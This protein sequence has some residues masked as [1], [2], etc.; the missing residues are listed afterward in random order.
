[1][2]NRTY[3]C[4]KMETDVDPRLSSSVAYSDFHGGEGDY[5][6]NKP[7]HKAHYE[8]S[9][10]EQITSRKYIVTDS[11]LN[12]LGTHVFSYSFSCIIFRYIFCELL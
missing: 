2:K 10:P 6:R 1:M 5:L 3:F 8:P 4:K 12:F 11:F 9:F 7:E